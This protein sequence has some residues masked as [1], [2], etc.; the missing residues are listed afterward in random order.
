[1]PGPPAGRSARIFGLTGLVIL[2][3]VF[4]N[5]C[6]KWG[7]TH[8]PEA[9]GI[10]PL[11]YLRAMVNPFVALG[12]A[13]LIL[14]LLTRMVLLSWADL[15]LVLPLTAVGYVMNALMDEPLLHETISPRRWAGT[16][17]IFAGVVLV[18]TALR[19]ETKKEPEGQPLEK[20]N[21]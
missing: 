9:L 3:N 8:I 20:T 1:M 7:V 6:L 14:W 21:A 19:A 17:C 4:G 10:N 5:L 12:I 16:L 18:G 2:L 13:L 15:T 11:H